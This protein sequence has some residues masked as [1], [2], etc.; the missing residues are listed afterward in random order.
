MLPRITER[1]EMIAV[2]QGIMDMRYTEEEMPGVMDLLVR[3]T[4]CP[5]VSDLIFW[6]KRLMMASEV[7]DTALAHRAI[8]LGDKT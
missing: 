2:V 3:S 4:G 6:P 5:R 8:V 7:I 1:T